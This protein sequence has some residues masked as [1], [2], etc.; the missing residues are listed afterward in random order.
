M[1][2]FDPTMEKRAR[3]K[4]VGVGGSGGNAVNRM[5]ESNL[6]GV[7]FIAMNTD[8]QDLEN[9]NAEK[10]IQLG[11]N[12]TNGLGAGAKIQIGRDA[13]EET[14]EIISDTLSNTD[15]VFI[16]AG[17][18]G[19]TGSGAGPVVAEVA[20]S[21][22][23]LTVGIV[24]KPF[25]CE[26]KQ[27][28]N[29]ALEGIEE[30]K[31]H[32][33][34]LIVIPNQRLMSIVDESTTFKGA[35]RSADEILYQGTKG[36]SDLISVHGIINLDFADVRTVMSEMGDAI[37]GTG[38]ASGDNRAMEAAQRAIASPLLEDASIE[39]A[40]GVLVNITGS[41]NMT[42]MEIEKATTLISEAAGENANIVFG[43]VED[44][45]AGDEICVTVIATGLNRVEKPAM[46]ESARVNV[47]DEQHNGSAQRPAFQ[48]REQPHNIEPERP[49]NV[50][51]EIPP[52]EVSAGSIDDLEVPTFLRKQMS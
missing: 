22:G 24:T 31:K 6:T 42:L 49:A 12:L 15:M 19:G 4:V 8:A 1:I 7:E 27:R 47:V 26:G 2:E 14:K 20:R 5:I 32:V 29:R 25:N 35:L 36:I 10:K 45:H 33:D 43:A 3:M 9:S 38:V 50:M 39:G 23:A 48:R 41:D 17:M 52:V 40:L 34:T 46:M 44:E 37:M 18:G 51:S 21:M 28:M 11:A 13:A 16:A 30:L